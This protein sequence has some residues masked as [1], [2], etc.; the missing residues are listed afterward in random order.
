MSMV[1]ATSKRR[2]IF[3]DGGGALLVFVV[4]VG[5]GLWVGAYVFLLGIAVQT[6]LGNGISFDEFV[7]FIMLFPIAILSLPFALF[8]GGLP[9]SV[10][11]LIVALFVQDRGMVP[12]W[13]PIIVTGLVVSIIWVLQKLTGLKLMYPI[14]ESSKDIS[15]LEFFA[16]FLFLGA[17]LIS[18]FICWLVTKPIQRR[19]GRQIYE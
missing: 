14:F 17:C 12:Y 19:C 9:A 13:L 7:G 15:G 16:S 11:G 1:E 8:L 18:S 6:S 2:S 10:T 5:F 3:S 4:F